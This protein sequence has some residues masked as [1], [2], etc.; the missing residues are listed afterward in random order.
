M[1]LRISVLNFNFF[2]I[3]IIHKILLLIKDGIDYL[4]DYI[5]DFFFFKNYNRLLLF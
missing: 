4:Q 2:T 5:F 1:E 3:H